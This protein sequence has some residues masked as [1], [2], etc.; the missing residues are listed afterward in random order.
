MPLFGPLLVGSLLRQE[1]VC[2]GHLACLH[3]GAK[4]IA[5]ERRRARRRNDRLLA[6]VDA[7]QDAALTGLKSTIVLS[8]RRARWSGGCGSAARARNCPHLSSSCSHG[9]SSPSA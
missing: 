5:R 8:C 9:R 3:L 1:G 4:N 7:I 2:A 6:L